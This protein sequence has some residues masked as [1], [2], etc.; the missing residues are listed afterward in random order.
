[1]TP[2]LGIV[3]LAA[4][5]VGFGWLARHPGRVNPRYFVAL[6]MASAVWALCA[7]AVVVVVVLWW[8]R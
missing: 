5:S 8:P 2:L 6:S 4:M 3:G 1:V 7:T